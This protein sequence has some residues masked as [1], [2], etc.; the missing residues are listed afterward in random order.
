MSRCLASV[1]DTIFCDRFGVGE[2]V[3]RLGVWA[4]IYGVFTDTRQCDYHYKPYWAAIN[5]M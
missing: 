2:L 5:A 4:G 1:R 3:K